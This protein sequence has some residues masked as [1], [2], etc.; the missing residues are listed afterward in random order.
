MD[1]SHDKRFK[2]I[3]SLRWLPFVGDHFS[4]LDETRRLLV[5]GESHYHDKSEKSIEKHSSSNF[6]RRVVD[7]LAINRWYYG[8]RIFPNLHRALFGHD[9]FDSR[10]FWNL[11]SFYNFIQRPMVT[12]KGR[13]SYDDFYNSWT[14]FFEIIEILKPETCLFIGTSAAN[15]LKQ[16]TQISNYRTDGVKWEEKISNAYAKSAKLFDGDDNKTRLIFIRHTS[17]MFSW[18]K[19]HGY[20]RN[21]IPKELD[22]FSEELELEKEIKNTAGNN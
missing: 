5:I 21:K 15:S 11:V 3:E 17:Q 7:E 18:K 12:N 1:L 19:W 9:N 8:T 14:T 22:W 13:P 10:A 4:Q 6:T 2:E 20:L 16:A